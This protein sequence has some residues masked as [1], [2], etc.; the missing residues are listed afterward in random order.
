MFGV[1]IYKVKQK[2]KEYNLS[3]KNHKKENEQ[4][5]RELMRSDY[6]PPDPIACV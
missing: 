2:R 3:K 5:I 6:M 4:R 1:S